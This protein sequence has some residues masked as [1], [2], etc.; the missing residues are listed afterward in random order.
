MITIQTNAAQI[1]ARVA[2]MPYDLTKSLQ[3]GN[4]EMGREAQKQLALITR[5][6]KH[7]PVFEM[8]DEVRGD[9]A[10]V[11]VGTNDRIFNML[12][13]GTRKHPITPRNAKVLRFQWG[14]VG[15]YS[16]KTRPGWIGSQGSRQ[17]GGIV[18]RM[19]VN[20]PGTAP[21]EWYKAVFSKL[22][23]KAVDVYVR[24]V[25]RVMK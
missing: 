17:T 16:A 7:K 12:D 22:R 11:L 2:R 20:H 19:S 23:G 4:R 5:T 1:A 21:R 9:T 24:A 14:G 10:T 18:F 15:S 6:W 25:K 13:Q 3:D 8:L